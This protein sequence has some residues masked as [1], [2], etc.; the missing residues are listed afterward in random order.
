M[1]TSSL[2]LVI[3]RYS[4]FRHSF[5]VNNAFQNFL[6]TSTMML[7]IAPLESWDAKSAAAAGISLDNFLP[8]SVMAVVIACAYNVYIKGNQKSSLSDE[9]P[10]PET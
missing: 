3:I 5:H 6:T 10:L 4:L 7:V 1:R 2:S 8:A 9:K